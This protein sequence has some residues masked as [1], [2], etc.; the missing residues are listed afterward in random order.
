MKAEILQF[1][2]QSYVRRRTLYRV[3]TR[4]FD[5]VPVTEYLPYI[6][7]ANG[8]YYNKSSLL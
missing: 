3:Y 2:T 7:L 6:Y 4:E 5:R 1:K 8:L